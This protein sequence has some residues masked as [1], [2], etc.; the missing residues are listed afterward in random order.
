MGWHGHAG[1]IFLM[2]KGADLLTSRILQNAGWSVKPRSGVCAACETSELSHRVLPVSLFSPLALA[3][4][5]S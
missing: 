4:L 5:F 1:S 2:Q 3:P